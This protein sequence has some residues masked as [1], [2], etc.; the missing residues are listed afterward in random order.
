M[1]VF[2]IRK[3]F[4][5]NSSSSHSMIFG[6]NMKDSQCDFG[7]FGW[8]HFVA[9]S[10][11]MKIAYLAASLC[12]Y[13][14][15]E[16][17]IRNDDCREASVCKLLGLDKFPEGVYVD[18]Q[19]V[20]EFP[21]AFDGQ[22]LSVEML[23]DL[24]R[25]M[26]RDDLVVLGGNDNSEPSSISKKGF[27]LPFHGGQRGFVCRKDKLSGFWTL[28]SR[29]NGNKVRFSFDDLAAVPT[30]AYVPELVDVKITE[31]CP[32]ATS[33][34]CSEFCYQ[35]STVNGKHASKANLSIIAREFCKMEIFEVA[36][37]GG[38]PTCHPDFIY[39]LK[40]FRENNVI[41]NFS[42]RNLEWLEDS[43]K[44]EEILDLC[45]G[46]AYSARNHKEVVEFAEMLGDDWDLKNKAS[47][48]LVLGT[49]SQYE[50]RKILE[51]AIERHISVT[52]LGFKTNG[53][54]AEFDKMDDS[55][56]LN[57]IKILRDAGDWPRV[58]IDTCIAAKYEK[59]ILE[60]GVNHQLF[61]VDEGKFSGYLDAV[62]CKFGPSSFCDES[63]MVNLP[64]RNGG[65]L[66]NLR[67]VLPV[68]YEKM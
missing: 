21:L 15:G 55:F 59:E 2:N 38:E 62:T 50:F 12:C 42:T 9:A 26:M 29:K 51:E 8:Q 54:G 36:L 65:S 20:F 24:K 52:L 58:S 56:W 5:T 37:G 33:S 49:L 6:K 23:D 34:G 64:M 41:P 44:R 14:E 1:K 25:F 60:A 28:F 7:N 13:F 22:F 40:K 32:Y 39:I 35:G 45:G 68:I 47:I 4:A 16:R 19:S 17:M 63:E 46:F 10:K 3:R 43:K 61:H 66:D 53:R 57:E 11:E 31:F 30:K 18:H 67:D 27:R 48:Q